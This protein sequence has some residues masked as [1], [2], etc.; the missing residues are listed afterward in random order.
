MILV[1]QIWLVKFCSCAFQT[2]TYHKRFQV[3]KL[4]LMFLASCSFNKNI[5][6]RL[7]A[8]FFLKK[9]LLCMIHRKNLRKSIQNQQI[10]ISTKTDL[11][12]RVRFCEGFQ[13]ILA[14]DCQWV[15]PFW[16]RLNVY[17]HN[18]IKSFEGSWIFPN[19]LT[20]RLKYVWFL[21]EKIGT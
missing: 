15:C 8:S 6:I 4:R 11:D 10:E 13:V 20:W 17:V 12:F 18:W 19:R 16:V 14:R 3:R 2:W 5:V 21:S 9:L 7:I 1:W